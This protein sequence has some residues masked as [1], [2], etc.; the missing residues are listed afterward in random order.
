MLPATGPGN[1][2]DRTAPPQARALLAQQRATP[3]SRYDGSFVEVLPTGDNLL[4][5]PGVIDH[6]E[7]VLRDPTV[8][9]S[10]QPT[11]ARVEPTP[12]TPTG[13]A[14][15]LVQGFNSTSVTSA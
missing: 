13:D 5:A 15:V 3:I 6:R 9:I 14:V 7:L 2:S 1:R 4:S 11:H 8:S 12:G 10:K